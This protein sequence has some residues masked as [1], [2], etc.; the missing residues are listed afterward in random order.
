M[1]RYIKIKVLRLKMK[2]VFL[3]DNDDCRLQSLPSRP[4]SD[5]MLPRQVELENKVV[6]ISGLVL[7]L[8]PRW[9]YSTIDSWR[10]AGVVRAEQIVCIG[11]GLTMEEEEVVS[12]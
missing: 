1:V 10:Q 12:P 8:H 5:L 4:I 3:L 9:L 6:Q 7:V 11:G 2:M